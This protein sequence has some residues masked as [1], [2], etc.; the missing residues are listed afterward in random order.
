M[1]KAKVFINSSFAGILQEDDLG[2][3]TR[4]RLRPI[5]R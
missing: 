4:K 5:Y 1:K 2:Y 3:R